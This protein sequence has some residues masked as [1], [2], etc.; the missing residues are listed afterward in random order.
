MNLSE[1]LT[2]LF[3]KTMEQTTEQWVLALKT[4]EMRDTQV[5]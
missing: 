4:I 2:G 3:E 1:R 5:E